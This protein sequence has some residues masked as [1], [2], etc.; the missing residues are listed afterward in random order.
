MIETGQVLSTFTWIIILCTLVNQKFCNIL[1]TWGT[2]YQLWI[3]L[4]WWWHF[5]EYSQVMRVCT[6]LIVIPHHWHKSD[7]VHFYIYYLI[8]YWAIGLMS[9]VFA[10][11]LGDRGSVPGWVIPKTQKMVLDIALLSIIRW[12][13]RVKW[14]NPGNGIAPSPTPRCRRYLKGSLQVTFN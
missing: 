1:A 8:I 7:F 11:G 3:L 10:N 6:S 9:R 5:R 2:I 13:S 4:L 14:S 12:E